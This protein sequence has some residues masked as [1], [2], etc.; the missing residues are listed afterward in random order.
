MTDAIPGYATG[1]KLHLASGARRW[2]RYWR[3]AVAALL[4]CTIVGLFF[5][6][7]RLE[8]RSF[9][10]AAVA[11]LRSVASAGPIWMN[12]GR[13]DARNAFSWRNRD[14]SSV[15][16]R[17]TTGGEQFGQMPWR[18]AVAVD[19]AGNWYESQ[20]DYGPSLRDALDLAAAR[21]GLGE[22]REVLLRMGFRRTEP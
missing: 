9:R 22:S 18:K 14:G 20:E 4:A 13:A 8:Q 21:V 17:Y 16:V 10:A 12:E 7:P 6:A 1:P 2:L 3:P 5:V 15:A 19:S 11:E